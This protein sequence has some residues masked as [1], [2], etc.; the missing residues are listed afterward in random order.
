MRQ[1]EDLPGAARDFAMLD[2]V[3]LICC[4]AFDG[5]AIERNCEPPPAMAPKF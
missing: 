4:G 2:E 3:K 1:D 5:R